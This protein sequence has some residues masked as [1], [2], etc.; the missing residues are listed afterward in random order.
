MK[1]VAESLAS[2]SQVRA[3]LET[4]DEKKDKNKEKIKKTSNV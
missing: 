4:K 3:A 2:K 1:E